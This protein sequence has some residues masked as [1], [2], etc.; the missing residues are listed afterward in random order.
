[1]IAVPAVLSARPALVR[2]QEGPAA[3]NAGPGR[4]AAERF[5]RAHFGAHQVDASAW[6]PRLALNWIVSLRAVVFFASGQFVGT[7]KSFGDIGQLGQVGRRTSSE[8]AFALTVRRL[9]DPSCCPQGRTMQMRFRWNGKRL[10]ASRPLLREGS[11]PPEGLQLPTRNIGCIFGQSPP[12]L[13]CDVRTGLRPPPPRPKGCE[14]DWAYGLEMTAVSRPK[15]FCAGD[16]A[17]S[18]GPILAYGATLKLM[19]F[20]CLSEPTGILCT[21][22]NRHGFFLSR[23]R[24]RRF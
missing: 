7:E 21:N 23:Q 16:T 18:A 20:N 24:W 22:R 5:V 2:V 13:R 9:S 11:E 12:Y 14:Q 4:A 17:L 6:K 3:V 8:V 19:G 10:I 1:M 15:T